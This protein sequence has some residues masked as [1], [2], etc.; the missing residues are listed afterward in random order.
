VKVSESLAGTI[1]PVETAAHPCRAAR[2]FVEELDADDRD[3]IVKALE[4]GV[5][6]RQVSYAI[7]NAGIKIGRDV[8]SIH[9]NKQCTCYA[10][11]GETK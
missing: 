4:N 10:K 2:M 8:L 11:I 5:S 3:A 1:V 7:R 9:L 6:I